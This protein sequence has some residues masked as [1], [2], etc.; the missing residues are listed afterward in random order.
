MVGV[1]EP[2]LCC[3]L[4]PVAPDVLR[5]QPHS[6]AAA[7]PGGVH[8]FKRQPFAGGRHVPIPES[9]NRSLAK[10]RPEIS[11]NASK[12]APDRRCQP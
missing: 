9:F 5:P 8:Q 1:G 10:L 11:D 2:V 6:I 12:V 7:L 3:K 4:K